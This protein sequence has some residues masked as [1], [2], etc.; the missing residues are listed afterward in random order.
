[1]KRFLG[2]VISS[3]M[4]PSFQRPYWKNIWGVVVEIM[5]IIDLYLPP[6]KI[7]CCGKIPATDM[8]SVDV[9]LFAFGC[10]II[11]GHRNQ[12]THKV[13][14]P[15]RHIYYRLFFVLQYIGLRQIG[16]TFVFLLQILPEN[17]LCF[18]LWRKA[19]YC[20]KVHQWYMGCLW[21]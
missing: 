9:Y 1:M 5:F 17:V 3:P 16:R 4:C 19:I 14:K 11:S 13:N 18:L 20:G 2:K 10:G 12:Y 15:G 21:R 6:V 8:V 7:S